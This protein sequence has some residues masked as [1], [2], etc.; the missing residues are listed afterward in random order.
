M[1]SIA[2]QILLRVDQV[3]KAT[4]P[5]GTMVDRGRADAQ[6]LPEAPSVIV[7]VAAHTSTP[8][9]DDF[10]Q[11]EL[12]LE[13]RIYVRDV[14]VLIAAETIHAAFHTA[15]VTDSALQALAESIRFR[16]SSGDPA[17]ADT[18]ALIKAPRYHF[19]YC[20]PKVQL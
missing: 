10:D 5:A 13:L 16:D 9:S 18:T 12:E 2:A 17:E 15:V 19:R 20:I 7:Q 3:L 14:D 11:H 6:S 1:T 8:F 4:V